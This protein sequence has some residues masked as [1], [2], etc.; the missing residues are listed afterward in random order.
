MKLHKKLFRDIRR[1]TPEAYGKHLTAA[2]VKQKNELLTNEL[3]TLNR[4]IRKLDEAMASPERI[5]EDIRLVGGFVSGLDLVETA[6]EIIERAIK[7]LNISK[8]KEQKV[9]KTSNE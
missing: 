4:L 2:Q 6:E 3:R 9:E 1:G 8:Q 7:Q 5:E